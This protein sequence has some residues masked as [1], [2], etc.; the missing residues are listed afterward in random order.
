MALQ[1][2]YGTAGSMPDLISNGLFT[3]G[4]QGWTVG[5]NW[6]LTESPAKGILHTAG[7]VEAISVTAAP[8]T[9]TTVTYNI[10]FT[11]ANLTAGDLTVTAGAGDV[12]TLVVD[13]NGTFNYETVF[14]TDGVI[15]FTPS[16]DFDGSVHAVVVRA[17]KI[18]P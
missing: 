8:V 12:T 4:T 1:N 15:S 9:V 6:A 2:V 16:T 3:Q 13:A 14:L 18:Q 5:A 17:L 10:R 7:A 11:V